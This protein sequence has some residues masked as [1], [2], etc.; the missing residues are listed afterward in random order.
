M[1]SKRKK[2]KFNEVPIIR[3][4]RR[5]IELPLLYNTFYDI[6]RIVS[7]SPDDLRQILNRTATKNQISS[8]VVDGR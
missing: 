3:D 4:H 6:K 5:D 1:Q 7:Y 2:E 8:F